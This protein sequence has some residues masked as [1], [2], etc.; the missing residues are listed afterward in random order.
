MSAEYHIRISRKIVPDLEDILEAWVDR[1]E[2]END[3]QIKIIQYESPPSY[4]IFGEGSI[5]GF[6]LSSSTSLMKGGEIHV[7]LNVMASQVDWSM[8]FSLMEQ[9]AREHKAAI[10][11][12][13]GNVLSVDGLAQ[14]KA[15]ERWRRTIFNDFKLFARILDNQNEPGL[16]LPNPRFDLEINRDDL[17]Q[18]AKIEEVLEFE[19][20]LAEK[21]TVL[22]FCRH[23]NLILVDQQTT[24]NAF[25]LEPAVYPESEYAAIGGLESLDA[26]ATEQEYHYIKFSELLAIL[27]EKV[28]KVKKDPPMYYIEGLDL[29][30]NDDLDLYRKILLAGQNQL[31]KK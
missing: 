31:P 21:A 26:P 2:K 17:K 13:D 8:C 1:Y 24:L 30:Q 3:L 29:S 5:R 4:F 10:V 19:N 15:P 20:K 14:D 7:R 16:I 6:S 23:A 22:A 9:L 11:D 12:E 27:G 25:G 28:R 18:E